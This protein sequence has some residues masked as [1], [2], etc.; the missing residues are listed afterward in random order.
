MAIIKQHLV[1]QYALIHQNK[2]YGQSC[3]AFALQLQVCLLDLKPRIVLEYG[4]GQ[5][6][7]NEILDLGKTL[8]I[9]YDPAIPELSQI[10]IAQAD[11]VVN[12]DVLEHIPELD[13]PDVL[14]HIR[15]FSPNVFFNIA[16]RPAREILPN[17]ENAHCTIWPAK[18]WVCEIQKY[19]P[20]A[21]VA[22][23]RDAYSC[24]ITTWKSPARRVIAEIELL[25]KIQRQ[26]KKSNEH[27]L[28]KFE[29]KIRNFRKRLTHRMTCG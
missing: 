21:D 10:E 20:E 27:C 15:S 28:K 25:K 18:K 23:S 8:W 14:R 24:I 26:A 22:Y 19:F 5:S 17:G 3:H 9:R 7:L 1:S 16:T 13:I 12:T 2:K 29:R 6:R 11:F 4:C